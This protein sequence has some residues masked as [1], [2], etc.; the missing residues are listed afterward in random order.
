MST[1][2]ASST[3]PQPP[4]QDWPANAIPQRWVEALFE[5]M[6]AFYGARFADLWRGADVAIVKRAWGIELAK[7]SSQQMKAGSE[8]LAQIGKAPTLPEFIAHCRQ[9]RVEAVA[10]EQPQLEHMPSITPEQAAENIALLNRTLAR[11]Q[12]SPPSAEW[13]FRLILRGTSRSGLP[14]PYSVAK[15]ATDAITSSAGK[16]VV[17]QCADEALKAEYAAIRQTV[18]DNYRARGQKLWETP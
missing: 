16:L 12:Q 1:T 13:A 6:T 3:S 17:E 5:K 2:T 10:S 15:C 7:L 14:L 18:I 9:C 4:S 8:N 11:M